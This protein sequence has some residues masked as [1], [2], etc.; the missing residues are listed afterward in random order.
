MTTAAT[1]PTPDCGVGF[2]TPEARWSRLGPYYAMFPISFA[3]DAI[4]RF[5]HPG[6]MV[7]DPFCGRGTAPMPQW[8][9]AGTPSRAR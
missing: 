6:D 7:L 9:P 5:T 8:S 3:Q 4:D 2:A 1:K